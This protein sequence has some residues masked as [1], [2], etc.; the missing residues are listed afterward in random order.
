MK[1]DWKFGFSRRVFVVM[2]GYACGR[3]GVA[4]GPFAV[5]VGRVKT[6][7]LH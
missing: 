7:H 2:V 3:F 6:Y 1:L 5:S 4:L